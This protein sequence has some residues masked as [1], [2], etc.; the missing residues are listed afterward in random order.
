M[1]ITRAGLEGK[2]RL[3]VE[4]LNMFAGFYG[5]EASNLALK[6]LATGGVYVGGGIA[7]KI[8]SKLED[9]LFMK[10]FV[11]EGQMKNLLASIPVR[12]IMNS[13]AALIGA[14]RYAA[15]QTGKMD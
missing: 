10:Q 12:V 4:T 9:S 2:C 3:C 6:M 8:I 14:A 11:G 1:A 13:K 5:A 7:P 15:I